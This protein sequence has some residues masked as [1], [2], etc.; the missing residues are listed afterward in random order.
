MFGVGYSDGIILLFLAVAAIPFVILGRY[1][2]LLFSGAFGLFKICHLFYLF[3]FK[4]PESLA[5]FQSKTERGFA[6]SI[7][8][9]TFQNIQPD[10]GAAIL[11]LGTLIALGVVFS[12]G[13]REVVKWRSTRVFMVILGV[14]MTF[15][16]LF[17]VFPEL[18]YW[19]SLF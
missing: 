8:E 14:L 5:D 7:G 16:L 1:G 6:R 9:I 3:W 19:R 13:W 11:L 18:R 4:L 10:W 2:V 12:L 17:V 15:R